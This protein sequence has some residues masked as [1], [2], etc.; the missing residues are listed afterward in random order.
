LEKALSVV[1]IPVWTARSHPRIVAADLGSKSSQDTNE[2]GVPRH[3]LFEIFKYFDF[4]PSVDC[5]ALSKNKICDSYYSKY[6]QGDNTAVNF[7]T[8]T[9][10][11]HDKYFMCPP[12]KLI[13][14]LVRSLIS[15]T[16][17]HCLLIIPYWLS[18]NFWTMIHDGHS[19]AKFIK[20]VYIFIC[21]P[22][23]FHNNTVKNIFD[24][25]KNMK[26]LALHIITG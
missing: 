24:P 26:M 22:M 20:G 6:P 13:G 3:L 12:T 18:S 9:L 17:I 10:N 1:T 15:T 25:N 16:N 11:V 5:F 7:F 23:I 21:K 8:Q 2:W 4:H 14:P 19:Y